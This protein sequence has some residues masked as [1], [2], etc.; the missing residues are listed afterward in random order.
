VGASV[1]RVDSTAV[2]GLAL[3]IV[4]PLFHPAKCRDRHEEDLIRIVVIE[5][6]V[7]KVLKVFHHDVVFHH[8]RSQHHRLYPSEVIKPHVF[9]AVFKW[10]LFD[11]K[12]ILVFHCLL[13]LGVR[14]VG[15]M[16]IVVFNRRVVH[17]S[18]ELCEFVH[19]PIG[20]V[21]NCCR[22]NNNTIVRELD[23]AHRFPGGPDVA[24]ADVCSKVSHCLIVLGFPQHCGSTSRDP[25]PRDV[26]SRSYSR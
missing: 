21:R 18:I 16:V 8:V 24:C 23:N 11:W 4:E 14:D 1:F 12:L 17:E 15:A 5:L 22:E 13:C 25:W 7:V 3:V 10:D 6:K 19:S 9:H 2:D 26:A 20:H